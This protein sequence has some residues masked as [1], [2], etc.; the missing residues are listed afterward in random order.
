[1]D[2][3]SL[4][5]GAGG[6][7]LGMMRANLN[8]VAFSENN[9]DAIQTHLSMFPGSTWL[10]SSV[11]G[12]IT[13]IPDSEFEQYRGKIKVVFAGFPCQGFSHAGKKKADDPRNKLFYEFLRAVRLIQP[14]WII[15]E[16]VA[17]LL[18]RKTDDGGGKVIDVIQQEFSDIGYPLAFK[19]YDLTTVGVAQNRK[20]FI[21][22]GNRLNI[23]YS[24][25]VFNEPSRG[26]R[27]YIQPT[28]DGAVEYN[29]P[30]PPE[31]CICDIPQMSV[32]GTAHPY[33]LKKL[34]D[35]QISFG[36]RISPTHAQIMDLSK[37]SNTIICAYSFQPRLFVCLRTPDKKLY[38]RCM[39]TPELGQI[40][41]FSKDHAFSGSLPSVVKQIGNA[42][43]APLIEGLAR[44]FLSLA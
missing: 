28:L 32:S 31:E 42:V 24:L 13:K 44:S 40:Q 22:V 4:F 35:T 14:E 21:M 29:L 25:P 39:T 37:P 33:L 10:G 26:I 18:S 43:P 34:L 19:V 36:K 30:I 8:V 3:I 12:D 23:P 11:K 17:G 27:E 16:N 20:R 6:D 7:T 38:I 41:G 15:G 5:S 9:R 1:M 2:A